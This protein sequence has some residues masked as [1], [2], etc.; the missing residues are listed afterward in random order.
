MTRA[1]EPAVQ[2]IQPTRVARGP[3]KRGMRV[4]QTLVDPAG[5]GDLPATKKGRRAGDNGR[6]FIYRKLLPSVSKRAFMEGDGV[7]KLTGSPPWC[8]Y[9]MLFILGSLHLSSY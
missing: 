9:F 1:K 5:P 8:I 6:R 7:H 3:P 2:A 4:N